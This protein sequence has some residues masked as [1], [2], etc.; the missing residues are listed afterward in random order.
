MGWAAG[1]EL[2]EDIYVNIKGFIPEA[3]RK[4]VANIIYDAVC[5]HDADDWSGDTELEKDG[6]INQDLDT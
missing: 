4:K 6:N 3:N 1:A 5:N 2:A